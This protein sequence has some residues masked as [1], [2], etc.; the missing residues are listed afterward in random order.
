MFALEQDPSGHV[1]DPGAQQLRSVELRQ[2]ELAVWQQFAS[3]TK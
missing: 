1:V 2:A 3:P